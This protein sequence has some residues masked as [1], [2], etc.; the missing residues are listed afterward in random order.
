MG[1]S[2]F[3]EIVT[4]THG[5]AI[6]SYGLGGGQFTCTILFGFYVPSNLYEGFNKNFMILVRKLALRPK[7]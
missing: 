5:W 2:S 4:L 6:F 3:M 7:L 1:I